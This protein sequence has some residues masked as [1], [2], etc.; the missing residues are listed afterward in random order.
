M[1][2]AASQNA[3]I[4]Q[5]HSVP[6]LTKKS[7]QVRKQPVIIKYD[8]RTFPPL[9]RGSTSKPTTSSS[10]DKPQDKQLPPPPILASDVQK[11]RLDA[12]ELQVQEQNQKLQQLQQAIEAQQTSIQRLTDLLED[13]KKNSVILTESLNHLTTTV[14][15]IDSTMKQMLQLQRKDPPTPEQEQLI[16]R[17]R[18]HNANT[19]PNQT[20]PN[21]QDEEMISME[22]WETN[23]PN[24]PS[25]KSEPTS[26]RL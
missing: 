16:K 7:T 14:N 13:Q 15:T 19:S 24:M 6:V 2:E 3:S 5:Q 12:L 10:T 8:N 26:P 1:T 11:N 21:T 20:H 22:E 17:S 25:S 18:I 9:T 23:P 4:L